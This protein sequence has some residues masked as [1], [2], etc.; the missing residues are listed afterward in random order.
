MRCRISRAAGVLAACLLGVSQ[1]E[2]A[3]VHVSAAGNDGGNGQTWATAKKTVQA[4]L[5]AAAS[6]DQI[7]VAAGTY[8]ENITLKSEVG[9][10]GGFAGTETDLV[11]R[12]WAVNVTVLD[13][14]QAGSVVT[15]P[16]G[17]MAT[18]RVD[19]FTI[20]NGSF[21]VNCWKSSPI[22]ADN[23]IAGN[24]GSGVT[25]YASSPI[26]LNNV[27]TGNGADNGAGIYCQ[28]S[29]A[30]IVNNTI[31][32]NT[33]FQGGGIYCGGTPPT[34]INN[35]IAFNSSGIWQ[36]TAPPV[37]S[38]RHNCV[39]GNAEYN[40]YGLPDQTGTYGNVS[41]DPGLAGYL[42]GGVHIQPSS[43]CVD[44]GDDSAVQPGWL[45]MDGQSRIAGAH[46]DIG[47]DES[48][49][50][51]WP[52]GP[53]VIARVSQDGNDSTNGSSWAL[54]KRTIQAGIDAAA[55]SGGEVWVRTG[56]YF[57]RIALRNNV[58]VYGG[59]VGSETLRSERRWRA[60]ATIVDGS[61]GG[62]VVTALG[63]GYRL[64]TVD[65]FTICNGSGTP[66]RA[67]APPNGGGILCRYASPLIANNTVTGNNAWD[68]MGGGICCSYSAAMIANSSVVANGAQVGGGIG[69]G[70]DSRPTIVNTLIVANTSELGGGITAYY[71][72]LRI[73][74]CTI[75]KNFNSGIYTQGC[76]LE[77][78]STIVAFN[79]SG[80]F[81][82]FGYTPA[83]RSSCVYG[84]TEG[85]YV[86]FADPT[87]TNG[88]IS[89]D[90]RFVRMPS[91]GGDGWIDYP[92]SPN[93]DE[94][95]NDDYGDLRLLPG[96]PC[97]DAGSN[98]DVPA[99]A[100]DRDG[101]G[102]TAEPLPFDLAGGGR[103]V[104]DPATADSGVGT[105]PIVDIG[106]YEYLC[107]DVNGDSHVDVVD[108]LQLAEAWGAVAGGS[109]YNA[110][111][112]CNFDGSVDAADLLMLAR[113]WGT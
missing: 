45:D 105:A 63:I 101:D 23:R 34:I 99:D 82:L 39:Y 89:A 10:Y 111:C 104:D 62:S 67:G 25:C 113:N 60:N 41:S 78:I 84:N 83:V 95:A 107:G 47:A 24:S 36:R 11:Q 100:A 5:N 79:S 77:V 46:V 93:I 109:A 51:S 76:T 70:N 92:D 4:G 86:N 98:A 1:L 58:H 102:N 38:Q 52:S 42:Y 50:T 9:L 14:N 37:A 35:V 40:C 61:Q 33:A 16:L 112:D 8:V 69:S 30:A 65:G 59:F 32:G 68:G 48:D 80:I 96:S 73:L 12:N 56:T 31:V 6:G 43:P 29:P 87:G 54:A 2:A 97:I 28:T 44:A 64:A 13:G 22:I 55:A 91:D 26:I 85:N 19:G 27:I 20:R 94:G 103:F 21:G 106:A 88:N 15:A 3:T 110:G 75:A 81:T 72:F 49:G 53:S 57:E 71:S 7:W 108:L 17:A 18:T 90:P 66:S 74:N